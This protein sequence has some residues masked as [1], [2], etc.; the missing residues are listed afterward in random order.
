MAFGSVVSSSIAPFFSDAG[1]RSL[2]GAAGGAFDIF[3]AWSNRNAVQ[4]ERERA[5]AMQEAIAKFQM[6]LATRSY[7]DDIAMRDRILGQTS[8]LG[9]AIR[10]AYAVLGPT[11]AVSPTDILARYG[12]LREIGLADF[13]RTV[14]RVSTQGFADS[15]VRGLDKSTFQNDRAIDLMRTLQPELSKIDQ[16]AWTSAITQANN[17][18][19][20][21]QQ[22][23][24]NTYNEVTRMFMPQLTAEMNLY[25]PAGATS[26]SALNGLGYNNANMLNMLGRG[27]AGANDALG[28]VLANF[29]ERF[30]PN[31]ASYLGYGSAP[32]SSYGYQANSLPA[33]WSA[34]P[35]AGPSAI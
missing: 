11:P 7:Q 30:A 16:A 12:T 18:Q 6:G 13:N 29:R 22:G 21:V 5:M 27:E 1:T 15:I 10:Q 24:D 17:L 14:D 9:E 19:A 20:T 8:A 33:Y 23:R 2:I 3:D 34:A 32:A 25:R 4:A 28:M 31:L 26:L 35:G